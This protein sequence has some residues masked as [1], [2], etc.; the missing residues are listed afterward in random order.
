[1]AGWQV[2]TESVPPVPPPDFTP[3]PGLYL[4][5][6]PDVNQGRVSIGH[7]GT[8]RDDPDRYKLLVMN[9]IL[10]GGGFS[11]R[12]LTRIRS[13]EGLA[14]SVGSSFGVGIY[15]KGVFRARLPVAQRD[16]R[17]GDR[18]RARGGRANPHRAGSR[19]MS[20]GIQSPTSS[21]PSPE[22]SRAPRR[23]PGCSPATSTPAVT[24]PTWRCIATT[25]PR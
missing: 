7:I 15:Y 21:R 2:G 9:D 22:T 20:S 16:R 13:D 11:A 6:K 12:L 8:T 23:L 19:T 1:M 17:A 24:R 4:V 14:Y 5:D 3:R 10:G 25:S 18:D